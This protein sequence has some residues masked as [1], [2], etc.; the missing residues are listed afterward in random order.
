[1]TTLPL[2]KEVLHVGAMYGRILRIGKPFHLFLIK[3]ILSMLIMFKN[4]V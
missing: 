4:M 1:M 2:T 3:I